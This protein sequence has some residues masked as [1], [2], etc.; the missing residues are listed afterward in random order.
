MKQASESDAKRCLIH[1]AETVL[2]KRYQVLI[3]SASK[4][5]IEMF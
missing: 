4:K 3:N 5:T 2:Q 1:V